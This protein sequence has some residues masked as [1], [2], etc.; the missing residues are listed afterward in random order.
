MIPRGLIGVVRTS[1]VDACR[2]AVEGL[3]K[4]NVPAIEIT[5]TVPGALEII[6]E[7]AHAGLTASIGAG[8]VLDADACKRAIS[9]GA[10]FVVSPATDPEVH[11]VARAANV[12]YVPGALTPVEVVAAM[13]L[14]IETI[15]IF[16]VGSLGG[17]PYIKTL[18]DPFPTLRPVV[19]G[20]VETREFGAY[21][22]AGVHAICL[23]GALIDH[24]AAFAG[25]V[26]AVA[27]RARTVLQEFAAARRSL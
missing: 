27:R 10:A 19:S 16:P 4:A 25:D 13:R 18:R 9:A 21:L 20:G 26:E 6:G 15:K 14:G 5:M 3:I 23:G 22:E 8:T 1:S 17:A 24:E 11:D 12:P 2:V 7:Y